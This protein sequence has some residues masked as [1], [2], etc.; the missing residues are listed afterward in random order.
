MEMSYVVLQ[1]NWEP[2]LEKINRFN[3]RN[4]ENVEQL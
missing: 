3:P 2:A 4:N 1:T